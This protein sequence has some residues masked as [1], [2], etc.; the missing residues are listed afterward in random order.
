MNSYKLKREFLS[1][2]LKIDS[3]Q[4]IES[5]YTNLEARKIE[6]LT[7]LKKWLK[8]RSELESV[9]DEDLAWRYIKM[10]CD[11]NDKQLAESFEF[12]I[13]ELEPKIV[14]HSNRLDKKLINNALVNELTDSADIIM[15]R[16][17]RKD[18]ELFREE[19]IPIIA[20]MQKEEQE[21]GKIASQMTI[22]Y[23]GE[24]MTMHH[25]ANLLKDTD[26]NVRQEVFELMSKRRIRDAK[27]L[28]D[29]LSNLI[30]K[31][32]EIAKNA[33]FDNFRDFKAVDLGR[34][35][36]TVDDVLTFHKSIADEV[37]PIVNEINMRRKESLGLS[38][39][40][41][42]D[43]AVDVNLKPALKP[44]KDTGELIQKTISCFS[45]IK[46]E[47]G[48][49]I[50]IMDE[51]KF[52]DLDSRK[53]K[54]PGGFNYPLHESNIPFIFMN[55]TGNLRDLETMV[56]EGGHAIHSFLTAPLELVNYKS[57]PS[58][59]AEL[60]SMSMELISMEYWD[61]FF[62]SKEELNRAKRSQ[63]EGVVGVLPW[64]ATVDKFQ[65]WL[66]LN[67][68]HSL[69]ERKNAWIKIAKEFGSKLV[70]WS[71][72]ESFFEIGWQKQLHIFEVPFYYIEY[73]IS[74]LG[75]IAIWKNFKSNPQMAI[76]KYEDALKL[77]YKKTVPE[78]YEAAG[79]KFDFTNSYV[80][81]L[82]LFVKS[83][84]DIINAV[85]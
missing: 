32:T 65:H 84:L 23:K 48:K 64:V 45:K 26:R 60:A 37:N 49:F 30:S 58:E 61:L 50:K 27:K 78:I 70:D 77:G 57:T 14:Y 28:D 7:E 53:G 76:Q 51:L 5:Y 35:D 56:H 63:L 42:W 6:T 31:R 17:I 75:A 10:N 55:A 80:R 73:A 15:L 4:K 52:L 25:A 21:Y 79:I 18:I 41:P 11:T 66:Y 38:K 69:I 68:N 16:T 44:F 82:M 71:G 43:L 19:N 74:Q 47:F 13:S 34:F 33:G 40:R 12:F 54:A 9:I 8:D 36:Y 81:E 59:V 67:P 2:G 3:W 62:E 72:Y 85:S 22:E 83:E 24:E 29:L 39:L 20:E 46:P 1:D